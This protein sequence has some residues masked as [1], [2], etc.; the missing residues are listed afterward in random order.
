MSV[1]IEY[2]RLV[3][4]DNLKGYLDVSQSANLPDETKKYVPGYLATLRIVAN[5][6][7]YGFTDL[8]YEYPIDYDEVVITSPATLDA[9]AKAAGSTVHEIRDLNPELKQ[10]CTPLNTNEYLLRIP[11]GT[12]NDFLAKLSN[13]N[14]KPSEI[15]RTVCFAEE[16]YNKKDF[17]IYRSI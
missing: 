3:S 2:K 15:V 14:V 6:E 16:R 9:I 12:V 17:Q 13:S 4:R 1:K 7:A 5:P 10:W 8:T 11:K